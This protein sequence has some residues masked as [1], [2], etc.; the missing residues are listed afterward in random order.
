MPRGGLRNPAGGR[1]PK[2]PRGAKVQIVVWV[3]AEEAA[4]LE[5]LGGGRRA[6]GI[7]A[8]L[9]QAMAGTASDAGGDPLTTD[10]RKSEPETPPAAVEDGKRRKGNLDPYPQLCGRCTRVGPACADCVRKVAEWKERQARL[11]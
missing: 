1:K 8:L 11:A 3:L 5:N 4:Y 7:R 2:P 10:L 6:P 9:R